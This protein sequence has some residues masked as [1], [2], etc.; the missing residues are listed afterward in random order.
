MSAEGDEEAIRA[1][2]TET[3]SMS[4]PILSFPP[5]LTGEDD[6]RGAQE[7]VHGLLPAVRHASHR[8]R[9]ENLRGDVELQGEGDE[10]AETVQQ[11]DRLVHPGDSRRRR[12]T[13]EQ[14]SQIQKRNRTSRQ[15]NKTFIGFK[16]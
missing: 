7:E 13:R 8:R 4:E 11:L 14:R 5:V 12:H 6:Q 3:T 2:T 9:D 10:D 16:V 1:E 15:N